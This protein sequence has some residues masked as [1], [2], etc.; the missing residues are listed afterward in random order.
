M[1]LK[2]LEAELGSPQI[3]NLYPHV[4][5]FQRHK[6]CLNRSSI[7]LDIVKNPRR[8]QTVIVQKRGSNSWTVTVQI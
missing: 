4:L 3:Y 6:F 2:I 5:S 8:G 7:T 1:I